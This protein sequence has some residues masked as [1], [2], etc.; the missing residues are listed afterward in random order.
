MKRRSD[1][2]RIEDRSSEEL[3][4]EYVPPDACCY[5]RPMNQ[6]ADYAL[7]GRHYR[8]GMYGIFTVEGKYLGAAYSMA[9]ALIISSREDYVTYRVQ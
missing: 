4:A 8:A 5:V 2:P 1:D 3:F 6:A 7:L 9:S